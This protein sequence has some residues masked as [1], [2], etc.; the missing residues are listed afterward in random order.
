MLAV[1]LLL[2]GNDTAFDARNVGDGAS[3]SRN[4]RRRWSGSEYSSQTPSGE[5]L[6]Q[7]ILEYRCASEN[8]FEERAQGEPK[9]RQIV[10]RQN[11]QQLV[12]KAL[13]IARAT[14]RKESFFKIA[15]MAFK[16]EEQYIEHH[17]C[18]NSYDSY[19]KLIECLAAN[20]I[21]PLQFFEDVYKVMD[22]KQNKVNTLILIGPPDTGKT[23]IAESIAKACVYYCNIQRF[24]KGQ[25]FPFMEAVGTRCIMINEP[26]ITDELV[27]TLKN[28]CEGCPC[29]VDVK[30]A[31][32]QMLMRTPVIVA[33]NHDLAMYVQ[34]DR[35]TAQRAFDSRSIKYKISHG[36]GKKTLPGKF[37]P[38]L[39]YYVARDMFDNDI[40]FDD[41]PFEVGQFNDLQFSSCIT[42]DLL[43]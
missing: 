42:D 27:E 35:N 4:K 2:I 9:F 24:S 11:F 16:Y 39:W 1:L 23:T 31:K 25:A 14:V 28:I 5:W 43:L 34:K 17:Q 13:S 30:Y 8:E 29:H 19:C 33:G 36:H 21:K 32:G 20:Q 26:C 15:E 37:N 7:K 10:F 18:M 6:V 22:K 12:N 41:R 40:L 38:G 3:G